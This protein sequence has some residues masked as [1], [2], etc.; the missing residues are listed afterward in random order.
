MKKL[1]LHFSSLI[2]FLLIFISS[3]NSQPLDPNG[4]INCE[5][6][7]NPFEGNLFLP[8]GRFKPERTN[9]YLNTN[10]YS[11]FRILT[12]FVQFKNDSTY[13]ND[14]NWPAQQAPIF[15]D[16]LFANVR[17]NNYGNEWWNA[18]NENTECISDY[19]MEISRGNFHVLGKTVNIILPYD[20][21]HYQHRGGMNQLNSDIY[22][23]LVEYPGIDWPSFEK[24]Y[25]DQ[26]ND[27][28]GYG[29]VDNIIDMMYV[30]HR[31][32]RDNIRE[33]D[34]LISLTPGSI[35]YLYQSNKGM[36]DT[37][38]NGFIINARSGVYGSGV[39][40]TTGQQQK[41]PQAP[42]S[43]IRF[44]GTQAH[45]LGHYLGFIFHNN[46]GLMMGE[47]NTFVTGPDARFSPWETLKLGYGGFKNVLYNQINHLNDFSSRDNNDTMQV[48]KIPLFDSYYN[49][50]YFLLAL[51]NKVLKY[52]RIMLGDTAES[53]DYGKGL[54]IYHFNDHPYFKGSDLE[55]ADGLF[56]WE[57]EGIFE[58]DWG[59]QPLPFFKQNS[60]VRGANDVSTGS[61]SNAD[62]KSV[63]GYYNNTLYN[64]WGG[65]GQ[66]QASFGLFGTDKIYTNIREKYTTRAFCGDRWDAWGLEYNNIFSPYSSPS[67][68]NWFSETNSDR[69][70]IYITGES[71][72]GIDFY[73]YK[74][75]RNLSESQILYLT[76]PS[77]PMGIKIEE[78]YPND[79]SIC[80]PRVVWE[81]NIE[82]DMPNPLTG[83]LKYI[84]YKATQPDMTGIPGYYQ[85]YAQVD[86][87]P[88]D[89]A[90]FID[91]AVN[92]YD[93]ANFDR[94]PYGVPYPIRYKVKAVDNT[95]KYSVYSDF[96]GTEGISDNGNKEGE[97]GDNFGI[98]KE[99]K[100]DISQNFPN[101]FN[102]STRFKYVVPFNGNVNITIYDISG[103][104]IQHLVNEY[105]KAGEYIIEFNAGNLSSGVYFYRIRAGN[106]VITKKMI[107]L[108]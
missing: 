81:H 51:R 56:N 66:K 79:T 35:A 97:A 62:G 99:L 38:S 74:P 77:R 61:L 33:Q 23:A 80:H 94:P 18:Y 85:T 93:C 49:P 88:T 48:L 82:P 64:N 78:Y 3:I 24:W 29:S 60:V 84:V 44:L 83:K 17:N 58:P 28:F 72:S 14:V 100:F 73:V 107:L 30:V 63:S 5:S 68:I 57:S 11:V 71:S 34:S 6:I 2:C 90:C 26:A 9:N 46:Y 95:G 37:L 42:F 12:V 19:F 53:A 7:T 50:D 86:I 67:T 69:I 39:T 22:S 13:A 65:I 47:S 16:S 10:Q 43:K 40:F 15:K 103:R 4:W 91:Y 98:N 104:E 36:S 21:S 8:G 76:P 70:Y 27:T 96:V 105:K 92:E 89:T 52:D 55:C 31:V 32:W 102:P 41:V 54:Y 101:P 59:P 25:Y 45:E 20:S 1:K 108:K 106:N 87:L 75:D